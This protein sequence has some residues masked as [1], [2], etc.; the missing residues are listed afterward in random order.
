MS[1]Q[2]ASSGSQRIDR[3]EL[4]IQNR[5]IDNIYIYKIQGRSDKKKY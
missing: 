5:V 3:C 1:F 4:L 2:K